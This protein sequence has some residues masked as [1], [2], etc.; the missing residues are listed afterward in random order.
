MLTT[1]EATPAVATFTTAQ[2]TELLVDHTADLDKAEVLRKSIPDW[3]ASADLTVVQAL[4]AAIE[5]SNLTYSKAEEV[6]NTLKPL[7]EF[8]KEQLTVFLKGKWTA[9]FDVERDTL[10]IITTLISAT[11]LFPVGYVGRKTTTSRTLLHAAMENFTTAQAR[12]GAIPEE[13]LIRIN[14]KPQT[15]TEITPTKFA[16]LCRE[17][18]LGTLY[19][20]HISQV[21]ALPG[22]PE[23]NLPVDDRATAA[24]IR[25]LK[26]LD[27]QVAVHIAYLKK[28]ISAAVYKMMLSVIKQDVPAAQTRGAVFDGAPV[29]WQGLTIHDA[30]VC[31]ALVFTKVSIDTDPKAKC[32]VYMPNEPRRPLYEYASLDEFKTYLTLHLQSKSYRDYFARQYL[33]GH[34][35]TD[36]FTEFDKDKTLGTLTATPATR[37]SDFF[38]NAFFSKTQRDA[39]ILAVPT[40]DVDEEQRQK[41]IQMLLDGGL[42]LLNAA[43]FFVPV[44]GQLMAIAA[45][46]DIVSEVY[47]G[48]EDWAHGE[49]TRALSH[50]LT[51]VESVAQMAAIA[52][53]GKVVSTAIGRAVKENATFFDGFEAVNRADGKAL[54]WKP[55]LQSYKQP[56]ALPEALQ[57]DSQGIYT[58]GEHSSIVMD[59]ATYRVSHNAAKNAWQ[60]KHPARQGAFEPGIERNVE[61]GWRHV[62]EHAHEWPDGGYALRR[63]A[64][65]LGGFSPTELTQ[66][67]EMTGIS[68][69]ELYR[70]H[71]GN[72][73]LPQRLND[74]IE[75]FRLDGRIT[76][77]IA[78]MEAGE[79]ANTEFVQ[80]Q[81][82]TL[83]R[84]PGWPAK[85]FIEVRD[86]NERVVSRFPETAPKDDDI[87]SV[88]VSQAQLNAGQLLETVNSGLH[89]NEVVAIVGPGRTESKSVLLA[90]KM[91]STLKTDRR[92]LHDWLY[93]TYDGD[94]TGDVATLREQAPEVPVRV[95][96]ELLDNASGRDR[97]FLR[98]RRILGFEL[99][100]QVSEAQSAIRLDRALTGLHLAQLANA[101]TDTLALRL[102][103]RLQGWDEGYR[104]EVRQGS[105]TGTLLDSAGNV[106]AASTGV[107][108]KTSAGYQV[109]QRNGTSL[110]TRTSETLMES[111]FHALPADQRTRMGLSGIDTLGVP[112]LRQRLSAAATGNPARTGQLLR[113]EISEAPKHL[114]NCVQADPPATGSYAKGLMRK[115]RK[116]YP[117]FTDAQVSSFLDEAGSTQMQRVNRIKALEQQLK[118]FLG[119]LHTWRDDEVQMKKLPGQLNDIR[120]SR[121]QVANAIENCWR[122]VAPPRWPQDQPFTTLKFDRNPVG[123][124][125]TLTEQDVA[126]VR[127]LSIKD[128]EA[129]DELAYF[130]RPFKGLVSLELDR[131]RLTRLPEA[132]SHMPHLQHLS[133]NGNQLGLTEHT[134]RKLADMRN[135]RTLGLSGNR[136]GATPDVSK[137]FHLESL[138]LRD[139]HATELPVGLARLPNL[140]MVDLRGNEIRELPAWLFD[141]PKRFAQTVNLR[142]NPLSVASRAKLKIYR[143]RTGIGMG[144]LDN[145]AAVTNEQMARDLWMPSPGEETY[146]GRNSTWSALK[147]EPASDGFFRL[148]AEAGSTADSRYLHEDMT[149]RVWS[150][151]EATQADSALRDQLLSMA[152][153]SNCTD[154][155]ATTFS[156][157][158]VAVDIDKVIRQSAN[159]HDQASRLLSLGRRLFRQ[160]Y[161]AKIAREHVQANPRLDPVEVEL[162]Y[163]TGLAEKLDLVG[164][165]RHMRYASLGGVTSKDLDVAYNR[166]IT[167]EL[168]P[169]LLNYM[170]NRT[171]WVDFL[172]QHHGKQFTDLAAPFHPRMEAAFGREET[173]GA[174][175]H[176]QVDGI[177][178][179][180]QRGET[181]L[182][183]RLTE[184]A[185]K[186]DELKTCFMLG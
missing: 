71:A 24:D 119:V 18:D 1:P 80:E 177:V 46:V 68:P 145:D 36:F 133:L 48:V 179:E 94:A 170:S 58:D 175:Y 27:M 136:L 2:R 146:A 126:H 118:S 155:A 86:E 99:A 57:P 32:V 62:H 156:N 19:Q 163:R 51:V 21:L 148:L 100:R 75:R 172:R 73:K 183:N 158:E 151:I 147:N 14:A 50:L 10:E 63:T 64:T 98:D 42:L 137:M 185:L 13:S 166:V 29:I 67:A 124:L 108:V 154:S 60:I 30:C 44:L 102:L 129:G 138:F 95:A 65:H 123:Q 162:A 61:G 43:S 153:K 83:P 22:N 47:E 25:R 45:V 121:R 150:V 93:K 165:P 107:I 20:R 140:D 56:S 152:V 160:D 125:P 89:S 164:Q 127:S 5:Q 26:L 16:A 70:L 59:E 159:A 23:S 186:A 97:S 184:E 173:P 182:L 176:A 135:L 104:L 105:P 84:L 38:F 168:S 91:A 111:I 78:A 9:D 149:R 82:H 103:D 109:T 143:D 115:V 72:L 106:D 131:N 134:L 69:A 55:D 49:R 35:K 92:P 171:F 53:G 34:D 144:F 128:M 161:L 96:K 54:L 180:L 41:T 110:T 101:D 87:N 37:P 88:R 66:I 81:L 7:D 39:R 178:D 90:N 15:G 114:S 122:R 113:G 3:L 17:L 8:C 76:R 74:C 12:P 6:L 167:A 132:L 142:H 33:P 40:A 11:G 120:V 28:N 77:L 52:V 174:E 181:S 31:G 117:L 79:S 116:L 141:V 112:V 169:E 4:K 130:L 139:T 157:I 85:R